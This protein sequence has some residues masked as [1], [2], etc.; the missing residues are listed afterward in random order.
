MSDPTPTPIRFSDDP[1][2]RWVSLLSW[3]DAAGGIHY[4]GQ[5]WPITEDAVRRTLSEQIDGGAHRASLLAG[6]DD[7]DARTTI[8]SIEGWRLLSRAEAAALGVAQT[9]D[10]EAYARV[11][12]TDPEWLALIDAKRVRWTSPELRGELVGMPW[13]DDTGKAWPLFV[14]HLA[15]VGA[16]HQRGQTPIPRLNQ[17]G[18]QLADTSAPRLETAMTPEEIAAMCADH[19]KRIA[20]LEAAAGELADKGETK[21]AEP[22]PDAAALSDRLSRIEAENASLRKTIATEAARKV[23][24]ADAA[25]LLVPDDAIEGLVAMRLADEKHYAT[26]LK[27]AGQRPRATERRAVGVACDEPIRL[28]DPDAGARIKA[29]AAE[30]KISILQA[31]TELLNQ[32]A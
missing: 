9:R 22:S 27:I 16:P 30:K 6:H 32:G 21:E 24:M 1:A 20:A 12:V 13:S 29:Y 31:R 23:V 14:G 17:V 18:V 15:I 11:E 4:R 25:R 26:A 8:G 5:V 19:E 28:G 3:D 2:L 7:S 10:H